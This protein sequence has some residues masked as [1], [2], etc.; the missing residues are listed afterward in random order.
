MKLAISRPHFEV[1]P[2]VNSGWPL[3]NGACRRTIS[4]DD[5]EQPVA[6]RQRPKR[7]LAEAPSNGERGDQAESSRRSSVSGSGPTF[8]FQN[9]WPSA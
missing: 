7:K 1:T 5:R 3:S 6:G 2:S 9:S 8:A 4:S